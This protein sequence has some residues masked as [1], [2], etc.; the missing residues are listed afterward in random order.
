MFLE[1]LACRC[2]DYAPV[3]WQIEHGDLRDLDL[4]DA[5]IIIL[6]LLP[7]AI[8]QLKP[9]LLACLERGAKIVAS[10]WGLKELQPVENRLSGPYRNVPLML[11]TSQCLA[12][13]AAAAAAAR[14]E[15]E[16]GAK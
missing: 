16:H 9:K 12:Q 1:F 14:T 3:Y 4:S 7:E 5:T 11:Y 8:E 10:T 13:V 2:L 15:A 6:Y